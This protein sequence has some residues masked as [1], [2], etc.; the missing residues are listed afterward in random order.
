MSQINRIIKLTLIFT[1]LVI[2][3]ANCIPSEEK[4]ELVRHLESIFYDS[5]FVKIPQE[6]FNVKDYGAKGDGI[7]LNTDAI[8]QAVDEAS[9]VGGG[10]V[11]FPEGTY[12]SG[13]LFIKSNVELHIDEDVTIKAI[14]DD[15]AFPDIWTR[16]A[17]IEMEWPAALINVNNAENVRIS[18][19]GTI[20]G[21]GKYWWDKFW[22]DPP[23]TGGMFVEYKKRDLRWALDYDCKRVR[24]LVVYKSE[25]VNLKNFRIERSGFWAVTLTYS[26]RVH[27]NGIV[28]RNNIGGEGPSSDGINTD[29][30]VDVLVENCDVDCNDD[31]FALKSGRG[32]DGLR[33][34]KPV[35]NVVYRNN[36][37]RAGHGLFTIGSETAG[38]M[39]NIEVYGLEAE[40]TQ[41]GIR[42]K[43]A[44]VRGGVIENIHFHD[45]KMNGVPYPFYFELNWFPSYSYPEIPEEIPEEEISGHW[46]KLTE[47]VKPKERGIPEFRDLVFEDIT[48]K[49]AKQAFYANAYPEK[50]IHN[51]HWENI[52]VQARKAGK[53]SYAEDWTMKNVT[54]QTK[55]GEQVNLNNCNDIQLPSVISTVNEEN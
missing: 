44:K 34:N 52:T 31:N 27:V 12:L 40:D 24:P 18:G 35:E 9:E 16:I 42:F 4:S 39:K 13:A 10:K 28:I 20:D 6:E 30:S 17:G 50:P 46:K 49:N 29:S 32:A 14:Q 45:I 2:C 3:F 51:L 15:D 48:V 33:V 23:R 37:S 19:K 7:T 47:K 21:N 53:I 36:L 25:N 38:G 22:G 41:Y 54:M 1:S 26:R 8:Q 5:S 55:N 43:S 11:I